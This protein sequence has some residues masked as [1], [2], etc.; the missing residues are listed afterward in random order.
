M[1]DP[2]YGPLCGE[3][4]RAYGLLADV[5]RELAQAGDDAQR[6]DA[7]RR[8]EAVRER[9]KRCEGR[10]LVVSLGQK[11]PCDLGSNC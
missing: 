10:L 1:G 5:T 4:E 2:G 6:A 7:A 8:L 3:L 11:A 9:I